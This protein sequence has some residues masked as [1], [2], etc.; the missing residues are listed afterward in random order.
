MQTKF[1]RNKAEC[2]A[3]RRVQTIAAAVAARARVGGSA[4]RGVRAPLAVSAPPCMNIDRRSRV[5][6]ARGVLEPVR[7]AAETIDSSATEIS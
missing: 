2:I 1:G 5:F 3:E 6:V 4:S 7:P